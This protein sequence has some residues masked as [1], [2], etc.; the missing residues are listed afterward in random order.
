MDGR[1]LLQIQGAAAGLQAAFVLAELGVVPLPRR[2]EGG[3]PAPDHRRPAGTL[4]LTFRGSIF[5]LHCC[6]GLHCCGITVLQDQVLP[7]FLIYPL[8][9]SP[10]K[11]KRTPTTEQRRERLARGKKKVS[12]LQ[13]T[14]SK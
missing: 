6:S 9:E 11:G 2:A 7:S 10:A 8:S 14:E 13:W 5:A 3:R 12:E 1:E 4:S